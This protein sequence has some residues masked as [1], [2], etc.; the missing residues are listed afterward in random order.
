MRH[1]GAR[2]KKKKQFITRGLLMSARANDEI[3]AGHKGQAV[4]STA[5]GVI[6]Q[7]IRKGAV[8]SPGRPRQD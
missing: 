2:L 5:T 4:L 6:F 7:H 8:A 1:K 3:G